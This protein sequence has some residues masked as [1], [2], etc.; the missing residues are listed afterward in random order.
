MTCLY[1][2]HEIKTKMDRRKMKT[3]MGYNMRGSL[4]GDFPGR[5][6]IEQISG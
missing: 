5:R 1:K 2:A 6:E 4:L 3:F